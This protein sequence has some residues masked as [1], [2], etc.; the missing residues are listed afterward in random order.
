MAVTAL[1]LLVPTRKAGIRRRDL[2]TVQLFHDFMVTVHPSLKL[3][4]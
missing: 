2:G 4:A 3:V 1:V